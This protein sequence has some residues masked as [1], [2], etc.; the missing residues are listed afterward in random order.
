VWVLKLSLARVE[1]EVSVEVFF[2]IVQRST[3][4]IAAAFEAAI[5]V[6]GIFD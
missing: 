5:L 3:A 6:H 2:A 4:G 1:L